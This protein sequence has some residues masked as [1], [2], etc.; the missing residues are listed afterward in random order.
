MLDDQYHLVD[1]RNES[2]WTEGRIEGAEHMPLNLLTKQLDDLPKGKTYLVHCK[3]GARSAIASSLLQ[4]H[5]YKDVMN[6]KGGYLA[7]LKESN[8]Q[9]PVI[10]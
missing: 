2:E 5:G 9:A 1:V 3:S 8:K 6:V 4:A 10:K 7:W